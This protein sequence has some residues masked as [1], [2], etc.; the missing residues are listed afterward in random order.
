MRAP[1]ANS[2]DLVRHSAVRLAFANAPKIAL[3]LVL[4]HMLS[5]G[6][7]GRVQSAP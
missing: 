4:A 2:V 7:H 3:R 6:Q 5:G 1:L